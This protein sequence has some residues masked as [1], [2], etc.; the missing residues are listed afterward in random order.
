M[1]LATGVW[2][3]V[4]GITFSCAAIHDLTVYNLQHHQRPVPLIVIPCL[5]GVGV[6]KSL[7]SVK[8]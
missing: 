8:V 2:I 3:P 4:T 5:F 1:T 6:S 7:E